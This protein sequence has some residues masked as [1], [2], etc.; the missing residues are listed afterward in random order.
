MHRCFKKER[1]KR[2]E[3]RMKGYRPL[4]GNTSN[5]QRETQRTKTLVKKHIGK[6]CAK[7]VPIQTG[8]KDGVWWAM[9]GGKEDTRCYIFFQRIV[10]FCMPR[11]CPLRAPRSIP[12]GQPRGIPRGQPRGIPCGQP[13]GI[14]RGQPRGIPRGQPRGQLNP[15]SNKSQNYSTPGY[16][17]RIP[18]AGWAPSKSHTTS[19]SWAEDFLAP[20]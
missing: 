6:P 1:K 2:R 4:G 13:R 8:R 3:K 14:P 7:K 20:L 15:L 11:G 16:T 5:V 19:L 12:R 18:P 17:A 9:R 10:T